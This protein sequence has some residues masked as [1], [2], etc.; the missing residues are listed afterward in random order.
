MELRKR[1][2]KIML[3]CLGLSAAAGALAV[4]FTD[5]SIIWRVTGT[6][7]SAGAAAGLLIP[8]SLMID[9]S[10][11]RMA[12]LLGMGAVIAEFVMGLALMWAGDQLGSAEEEV[13]FTMV[14]FAA[15]AIPAV[16][17]LVIARTTSGAVAGRVGTLLS[18]VVFVLLMIAV[19]FPHQARWD[20]DSRFGQSAGALG[21]FGAI[22][23]F[24]LVGVGTG[25]RR[26]W[27]WLGIT[28]ALAALAMAMVH[29]W[30]HTGSG[31][32]AFNLAV[33]LAAAVAYANL[34]IRIPLPDHQAW[35]RTATIGAGLATALCLGGAEVLDTLGPDTYGIERVAGAAGIIAS[36]GVLALLVLARMN[37][38]VEFEARPAELVSITL[39]CPRCRRKHTVP[40]GDSSCP[41]CRLRIRIHVE[42]P[43]C[44]KCDYLL[45]GLTSD[46]CPECGTP[47]TDPG[48]GLPADDPASP[49]N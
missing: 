23:T 1:L 43:R 32:M 11:A 22:G 5:R 47:I 37:R 14:F 20:I 6:G 9:R 28:A 46:R 3:W 7:L 35:V 38:R 8:F 42:D 45:T 10:K 36:C 25:D 41:S 19:W 21:L 27:R 2:L 13:G 12:G 18:A 31:R 24:C 34:L 44:R 29:I 4:L 40:I 48:P 15:A 39:F 49:K 16:V 17:F 26:H 30:A 33:S